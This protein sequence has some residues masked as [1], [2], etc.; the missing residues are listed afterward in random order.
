M[1]CGLAGGSLILAGLYA[2]PSHFAGKLGRGLPDISPTA[3]EMA[4][5]FQ[6]LAILAL[7]WAGL[8]LALATPR[9]AA[10]LRQR[11]SAV[12]ARNGVV[13]GTAASLSVG[14][15]VAR[16]AFTHEITPAAMADLAAGEAT[17]PFQYRALVPFIVGAA[18]SAPGL[19]AV[20]LAGLFGAVEAVAAFAAWWAF[21]RF[22][23]PHVD[24]HAGALALALFVPLALGL[25]SPWRYNAIYFPWDT[26]SVAVFTL[27]LAL[28]QEKRWLA[29]YALFVVGTLNR[30]TTCFLTVAMVL[31]GLG[32]QRLGPL[33]AHGA[34]QLALW[35]GVKAALGA[36]YAS[37][38]AAGGAEAA[39]L[40]VPTYVRSVWVL[41]SVPGWVYLGLAMGGAWVV[42][43]MLRQRL[44]GA[45]F[46]PLFRM[47]PV[48]LVG[49]V[50]VGE[51]MEVRIYSELMPL[52][53][54]S[55]VVA[56]V[57]VAR[58][59]SVHARAPVAADAPGVS[60]PLPA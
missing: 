51:L 26:V 35:L 20:P 13:W 33:A 42:V 28:M 50:L 31:G 34:A 38:A 23:T 22:L 15:A 47:V 29:F 36:A 2:V 8:L 53:T 1:L 21:R 18:A 6:V 3:G 57:S 43:L 10:A 32:R 48:F 59:A 17:L 9:V 40:F 12:A 30:E 11:L 37:N 49:M 45:A 27:G 24:G 54:A 56:L 19:S 41:T 55:L 39:G 44:A 4:L 25:A 14:Y 58:E 46:T 16:M 52:V 5:G 7:A 60:R